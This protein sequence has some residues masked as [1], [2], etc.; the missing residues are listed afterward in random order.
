MSTTIKEDKEVM[1][2]W[3]RYSG[4]E[5]AHLFTHACGKCEFLGSFMDHDLYACRSPHS[6]SLLAR[7]GDGGHE[8]ISGGEITGISMLLHPDRFAEDRH[9][10]IRELLV[11][12]VEAG[13]IIIEVSPATKS[14][15]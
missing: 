11:R 14:R 3:N 15:N 6:V 13:I 9:G 7:Y 1:K 8:Y 2:K 12:A 5:E 4:R 10:V